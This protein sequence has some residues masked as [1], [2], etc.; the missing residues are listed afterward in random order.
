M[1]DTQSTSATDRLWTAPAGS[2]ILCRPG[3]TDFFRWDPKRSTR[4]AFFHFDIVRVPSS[5]PASDAWPLVRQ[6]PEGDILRP[7]FRYLLT[8]V[9]TG[10]PAITQLTMQHMLT[11]FVLGQIETRDVPRESLPPAVERALAFVQTALEKDPAAPIG[12]D[13]LASAAD[14]TPEHLCRLFTIAT[15]RSPVETVRLARLD[16]A[17]VLLARSNYAVGE[18]AL[19][20]GFASPFHFSRRFKEAFGRSPRALRAAVRAGET[21]PTPHLLTVWQTTL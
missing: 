7:M 1:T 21:P 2:I 17:A 19:M 18:V 12:L 9:A 6:V 16:R 20:C 14:V 10:D 5:W 11:A 13:D 3:A 15:G 4:H 8:W